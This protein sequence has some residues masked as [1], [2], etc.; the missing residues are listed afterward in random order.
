M[1]FP[2]PSLMRKLR[3][4]LPDERGVA[5]IEFAFMAP[6][7]LL[8]LAGVADL[9]GGVY[10]KMRVDSAVDSAATYA[11][12]QGGSVSSSGGSALATNLI[13]MLASQLGVSTTTATVT[14]NN[15]PAVTLSGGAAAASGTG[16]QADLCYCPT[17]SGSAV[18]WGAAV[19]CASQCSNGGLAGKFVAISASRQFTPILPLKGVLGGAMTSL[20]VVQTQ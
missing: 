4:A 2:M 15:G 17:R 14:V 12:A 19:T 7:F 8:L 6:L 9:G 5:A 20:A 3:R 18:V 10:I 16:S 13:N 1:N 11:L